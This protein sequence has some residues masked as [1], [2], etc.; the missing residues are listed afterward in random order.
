M[1]AQD[2]ECLARV[3]TRDHRFDLRDHHP[4]SPIRIANAR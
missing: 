3:H 1:T 2:L 4:R